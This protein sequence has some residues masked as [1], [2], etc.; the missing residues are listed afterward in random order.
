MWTQRMLCLGLAVLSML[1]G[2]T[3][4]QTIVV[5]AQDPRIMLVYLVTCT[6]KR[7]Y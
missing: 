4:D 3:A 1:G 2:V 5:D 6:G 7:L